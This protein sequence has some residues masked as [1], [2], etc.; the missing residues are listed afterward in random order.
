VVADLVCSESLDPLYSPL[1]NGV[2][3][4]PVPPIMRQSDSFDMGSS[5]VIAV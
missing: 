1:L 4:T 5:P 3:K 2:V